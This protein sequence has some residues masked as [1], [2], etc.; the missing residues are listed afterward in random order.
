[1]EWCKAKG[2]DDLT[3]AAPD[4]LSGSQLKA[5]LEQPNVT[6]AIT[7]DAL[8]DR[9]EDNR[10][11]AFLPSDYT[12]RLPVVRG[13]RI[14][15]IGGRETITA[16]MI[17]A[18]FA[19]GVKSLIYWNVDSWTHRSV[20]TLAFHKVAS[21]LLGITQTGYCFVQDLL[22]GT[23]ESLRSTANATPALRN[24]APA[25]IAR[26]RNWSATTQ[27]RILVGEAEL[28]RLIGMPP[29]HEAAHSAPGSL[30]SP[31]LLSSTLFSAR[32]LQ[33]P[34]S[35]RLQRLLR[36][37]RLRLDATYERR[38]PRIVMACPTLVA[39][40]AERQ[41]VNTAIGLRRSFEADV[42]VLV[43]HLF[44]PPG[45]DFFY[46]ELQAAGVNVREVQSPTTSADTW[47]RYQT[48]ATATQLREL[49]Q[50][51][52]G[53]PPALTQEVTNVYLMLS[54]LR[55]T[56]LHAWLDHSSVCAGL[57]ALLAGVPRVILSGRN[58]SPQHFSYILQPYMR[59][60]YRA[61][62][63][64]GE[65]YFVNN[66]HGGAQDYAR[67]LGL[68]ETRFQIIYNG[69]TPD[70]VKTVPA[71]KVSGLR[72]RHGIPED[73]LLVGGMFRLSAEKRPLLW[74][75]TVTAVASKRPNVFGIIFG[76][77]PMLGELQAEI[78]RHGM[79][80]RIILAA[81]I[82]DSVTAIAAFDILLLTSR[83]EGTP[84]VAIEA[85]AI[86]TP[87]VVS[88]GGGAAEALEHGKTGIFVDH[89][90]Y[91]TLAEQVLRLA[92]DQALRA[93]L[94]ANGPAF[95]NSRFG[96]ARMLQETWALYGLPCAEPQATPKA[97]ADR[98]INPSHSQRSKS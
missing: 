12:W 55:P 70:H 95:V 36:T 2:I 87:V 42:T 49:R 62:A 27:R 1:M 25:V 5:L 28:R 31:E 50:L 19:G 39:G 13:Q 69:V 16:R 52:R 68:D 81:P 46:Q 47:I 61:M 94:G 41:I 96:L 83:W 76:A 54:D 24:I 22:A 34:N 93:Q 14:V 17:R 23:L 88:G 44:S 74:V 89:A 7:V 57:A 67:W 18:A 51:L 21:K 11:G 73:A 37:N 77:G 35:R 82:K 30:P 86:G 64:R 65:V 20:N 85:Q 45:N 63:K 84:N 72:R 71:A 60:A 66:S 92:D 26:T 98:Y 97:R 75:E 40:G 6:S 29:L 15:Y 32:L 33:T 79:G 48:P 3:V 78:A 53:L 80:K 8:P 59:P 43:S 10:V 90:D 9:T 38:L 56:V 4:A 58:V 91:P